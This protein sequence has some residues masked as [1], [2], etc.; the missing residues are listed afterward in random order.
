M[1]IFCSLVLGSNILTETLSRQ[2]KYKVNREKQGWTV[3]EN[4]MAPNAQLE[5]I[6]A[7]F[8]KQ[9]SLK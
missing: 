7:A 3:F 6:I 8:Y 5:Y 2:T 9:E 1:Q 4:W